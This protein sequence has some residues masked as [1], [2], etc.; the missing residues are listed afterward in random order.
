MLRRLAMMLLLLICLGLSPARAQT[1]TQ[2]NQGEITPASPDLR[3]D[4]QEKVVDYARGWPTL[5]QVEKDWPRIQQLLSATAL[6]IQV[7]Q[8]PTVSEVDR[9]YSWLSERQFKLEL[10][11]EELPAPK[12]LWPWLD[13]LSAQGVLP[14]IIFHLD[15]HNQSANWYR[16]LQAHYP[17]ERVGLLSKTPH[18]FKQLSQLRP[19]PELLLYDFQGPLYQMRLHIQNLDKVMG[20]RPW[21]LARFIMPAP[22]TEYQQAWWYR[23]AFFFSKQH[24]LAPASVPFRDHHEA[25]GH[26]MGILRPDGSFRTHFWLSQ[27]YFHV[28]RIDLDEHKFVAALYENVPDNYI[29]RR[30]KSPEKMLEHFLLGHYKVRPEINPLAYIA[31]KN[32]PIYYDFLQQRIEE[33]LLN[34]HFSIFKNM[35]ITS[36]GQGQSGQRFRIEADFLSAL[37]RFR[38]AQTLAVAQGSEGFHI[39]ELSRPELRSPMTV[40]EAQSAPRSPAEADQAQQLTAYRDRQGQPW[41]GYQIPQNGDVPQMLQPLYHQGPQGRVTIPHR[42]DFLFFKNMAPGTVGSGLISPHTLDTETGKGAEEQALAGGN[43][44]ALDNTQQTPHLSYQTHRVPYIRP[45]QFQADLKLENQELKLTLTNP[46]VER[47]L[48]PATRFSIESGSQRFDFRSILPQALLP[49]ERRNYTLP[50]PLNSHNPIQSLKDVTLHFVQG[51][52]FPIVDLEINQDDAFRSKILERPEQ[53]LVK[54][55]EVLQRFGHMMPDLRRWRVMREIALLAASIEPER[56]LDE[57]EQNLQLWGHGERNLGALYY[58]LAEALLQAKAPAEAIQAAEKALQSLPQELKIWRFTAHVY[59]IQGAWSSALSVYQRA[60]Q[61]FPNHPALLSD[62]AD[63]YEK[64]G[65]YT[66]AAET[67]SLLLTQQ[68]STRGY[69]RLAYLWEQ[70]GRWNRAVEAYLQALRLSPG[71]SHIMLNLGQLYQRLDQVPQAIEW[72]RRY[73]GACPR[74]SAQV[75]AS[76]GHLYK[77]Q[78]QRQAS[79]EMYQIHLSLTGAPSTRRL[80]ANLQ[81]EDGHYAQAIELLR[82]LYQSCRSGCREDAKRMAYWYQQLGQWPEALAAYERA[83]NQYGRAEDLAT[84]AYSALE[85]ERPE[86]AQRYFERAL[87]RTASLGS[88]LAW[89]RSLAEL[90]RL[91]GQAE[92]AL[93][94]LRALWRQESCVNGLSQRAENTLVNLLAA[95]L[96]AGQAEAAQNLLAETSCT[97]LLE[98]ASSHYVV[99]KVFQETGEWERALAPLQTAICLS[100]QPQLEYY[101]LLAAVYRALGDEKRAIAWLEE[102]DGYLSTGSLEGPSQ[103]LCKVVLSSP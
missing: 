41:W 14:F 3:P 59:R 48:L 23:F 81:A 43:D 24:G 63:S 34:S 49:L 30:F 25:Q 46:L 76:L 60:L 39:S 68:P 1:K 103:A 32:S 21:Q 15:E 45:R 70:S 10:R 67:L 74:C 37:G 92:K 19:E 11:L 89:Q 88:R 16:Q 97:A 84:V 8:L 7:A 71:Q 42:L 96:E 5:E 91:N 54:Y 20:R 99:G 22:D 57:L 100:E 77:Q 9:L 12:Q 56:A 13:S 86:I 95:Q 65:R 53:A 66:E 58:V 82:P 62:L 47:L 78:G 33:S 28:N 18:Q 51:Q 64:L 35:K 94:L 72:Y 85:A 40:L 36:L 98:R 79:I 61:Q 50:W 102:F 69:L 31:Y 87:A 4:Y 27:V 29:K 101:R 93:P 75:Y 38:F 2:I 80:L 90:Y 17:L 26:V 6:R 52:G 44:N 73:I 55:R 83:F